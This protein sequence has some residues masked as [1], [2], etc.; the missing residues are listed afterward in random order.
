MNNNIGVMPLDIS[1]DLKIENPTMTGRYSVWIILFKRINK[2]TA[3]LDEIEEVASL[4]FKDYKIYL[5]ETSKLNIES[6]ETTNDSYLL[7]G[8]TKTRKRFQTLVNSIVK[9]SEEDFLSSYYI[10]IGKSSDSFERIFIKNR[11]ILASSSPEA[12]YNGRDI[13]M[14]NDLS[15]FRPW[16][17]DIYDMIWD[18][19]NSRFQH[20]HDRHIYW[21]NDPKGNTGKSMFVKW[22]C[23]NSP[24]DIL[25]T[26]FGTPNQLRSSLISAG[27]KKC[28]FIDIPRT[29]NAEDKLDNLLSIIEDLKIGFLVSN[30][31]GRYS[32]LVMEP[33]HI[34]IFSNDKCPKKKLSE[35]R[36]Q[37]Y[38]ITSNFNLV[39]S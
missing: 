1:D 5:N 21:I 14:L 9:N 12:E 34:Y 11:D 29:S 23:V 24:S 38:K 30:F 25:K 32:R 19:R 3:N 7:I 26:S 15:N 6:M 27:P 4:V 13:M 20:P 17:R 33:P 22:M 36:W 18:E 37:S 28:Y 8:K 31:Y 16:Q 39:K 35:D 2:N 10:S